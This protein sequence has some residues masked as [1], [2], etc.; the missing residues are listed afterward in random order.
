MA[1][2]F[3]FF[4][5]FSLFILPSASGSMAANHQQAA[6]QD[7]KVS[8]RIETDGHRPRYVLFFIST[9]PKITYVSNENDVDNR[10]QKKKKN[11]E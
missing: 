9:L 2:K 11:Y 3:S 5:H 4:I 1:F 6:N 7:L 8:E 10:P